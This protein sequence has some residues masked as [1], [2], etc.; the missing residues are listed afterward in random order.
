MGAPLVAFSCRARTILG[1]SAA[2]PF[3][4]EVAHLAREW[5]QAPPDGDVVEARAPGWLVDA[6][7]MGGIAVGLLSV[8]PVRARP[9]RTP[10]ACFAAGI[11]AIWGGMAL[12]QWAHATL[13]RFHRGE[14]TI[15]A[16]HELVTA[17]P[18]AHVRHPLYAASIG[19]FSGIGMGLGTKVSVA[20]STALPMAA[21]VYRIQVEERA[22]ASSPLGPAYAVYAEGRKRLIPGIW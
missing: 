17:G 13:G 4:I 12:R 1:V 20:A 14:V 11:T 8:W 6:I 5:D 3:V 18:Y 15:H 2:L 7:S 21:H 10:R 22:I 16:D 9:V 19:V